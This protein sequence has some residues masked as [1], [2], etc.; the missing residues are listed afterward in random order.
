MNKNHI[1]YKIFFCDCGTTKIVSND[2]IL[3]HKLNGCILPQALAKTKTLT[4][5][6]STKLYKGLVTVNRSSYK[7]LRT[8]N[9]TWII[10][11]ALLV[12]EKYWGEPKCPSVGEWLNKLWYI[13]ATD[14]LLS[15]KK[16]WTLIH[17]TTWMDLKG[18]M[19][20]K[21]KNQ[22]QKVT[23]CMIPFI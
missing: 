17:A 7:L 22:S 3:N 15:N 1:S 20:S 9:C 8:K 19:F 10:T 11:A 2:I 14:L 21:K 4:N 16:E 12:T 5:S 6:F 23:C 13:N 18:F